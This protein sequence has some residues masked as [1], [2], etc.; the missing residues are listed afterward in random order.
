MSIIL[1]DANVLKLYSSDSIC[2]A[3]KE[4][5]DA[6]V[7]KEGG[8]FGEYRRISHYKFFTL[9]MEEFEVLVM[10][11]GMIIPMQYFY[12]WPDLDDYPVAKRSKGF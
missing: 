2:Y 12:P 5:S 10:A 11:I 9:E 1:P 3:C 8:W 7:E 6:L 4:A